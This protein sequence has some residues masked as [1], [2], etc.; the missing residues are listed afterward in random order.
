[1]C[2]YWSL[3]ATL[4]VPTTSSVFKDISFF[5]DWWGKGAAT[6]NSTMVQTGKKQS[7]VTSSAATEPVK[8]SV[9]GK[10]WKM[11]AKKAAKVAAK[12]VAVEEAE[13]EETVADEPKLTKDISKVKRKRSKDAHQRRRELAKTK[14]KD[15]KK[16]NGVKESE[17]I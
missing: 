7:S 15:K 8:S 2:S 3:D 6:A 9:R 17:G 16:A 4:P 1:V 5:L 11:S 10:P 12:P 14:V 13:E